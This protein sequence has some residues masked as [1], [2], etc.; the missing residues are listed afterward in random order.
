MLAELRMVALGRPNPCKI[1]LLF[2]AEPSRL[3]LLLLRKPGKD[4]ETVMGDVP[5]IHAFGLF[6]V[7]E[8]ASTAPSCHQVPPPS[9][10]TK[11]P[12]TATEC[13]HLV[14]PPGAAAATRCCR[15]VLPSAATKCCRQAAVCCHQAATKSCRQESAWM[16]TFAT[17]V[18]Y[19]LF[20]L[21]AAASVAAAAAYKAS[22]SVFAS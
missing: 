20:S 8:S 12:R 3:L 21:A 6:K 10:A 17:S 16:G 2:C 22:G 5:A 19:P 14:L 9:A 11:P 13:C 15:R 4:S 7:R 18:S 1:H